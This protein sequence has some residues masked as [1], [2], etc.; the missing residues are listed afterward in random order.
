MVLSEQGKFTT[1]VVSFSPEKREEKR[2]WKR[3]E[4]FM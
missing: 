3:R 4:S 2:K 1:S